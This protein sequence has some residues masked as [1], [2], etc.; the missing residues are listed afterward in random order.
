MMGERKTVKEDLLCTDKG[1]GTLQRL[2]VE[3]VDEC[4]KIGTPRGVHIE[5]ESGKLREDL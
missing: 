5:T 4:I 2:L 1:V 3:Q